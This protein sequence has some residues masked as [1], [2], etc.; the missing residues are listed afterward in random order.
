[1]V[2][3]VITNYYTYYQ[4]SCNSTTK[5]LLVFSTDIF[6]FKFL[7]PNYQSILKKKKKLLYWLIEIKYDSLH[8]ECPP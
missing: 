4:K 5:H 7:A 8:K 6:K 3:V 2:Y 1:M